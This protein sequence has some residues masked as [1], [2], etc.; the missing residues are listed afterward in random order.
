MNYKALLLSFLV[1]TSFMPTIHLA[2]SS[3]QQQNRI[4]TL[5]EIDQMQEE[6]IKNNVME[7]LDTRPPLPQKVMV[8]LRIIGL[9]LL[10]AFIAVRKAVRET[11]YKFVAAF[12]RVVTRRKQQQAI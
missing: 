5:E 7:T 9:P 8:W 10:N 4:T 6:M 1:C 3:P 2:T 11:W 12:K